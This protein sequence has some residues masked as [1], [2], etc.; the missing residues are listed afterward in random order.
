MLVSR[1]LDPTLRKKR[2]GWGTRRLVALPAECRFI[3]LWVGEAGDNSKESR[4]R[5]ANATKPRPE[6][7]GD[8][9][10]GV[11]GT[12][13]RMPVSSPCGS[14]T[15]VVNFKESRMKFADA[16]DLDRKSGGAERRDL[17]FTRHLFSSALCRN[18]AHRRK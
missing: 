5:F 4:M 16:A 18:P 6:I 13:C 7:R 3:P 17:R 12:S 2:E 15:P 14:A 1:F 11:G 8:G 9:A 10:P